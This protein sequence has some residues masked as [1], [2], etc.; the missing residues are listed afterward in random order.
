MSDFLQ[1]MATLSAERAAAV[2]TIRASD[3]DKPVATLQLG[4][5]GPVMI[6]QT[7]G[8][9]VVPPTMM[10]PLNLHPVDFEIVAPDCCPALPGRKRTSWAPMPSMY[11]PHFPKIPSISTAV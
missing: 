6:V 9:D 11:P 4:R 8:T 10:L 1:Q 3:L 5:D 7:L 2:G